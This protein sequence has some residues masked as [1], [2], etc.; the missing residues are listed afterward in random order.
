M[1]KILWIILSFVCLNQSHAD[2]K[3]IIQVE[4]S[5]FFTC[6]LKAQKVSCYGDNEYG[7]LQTPGDIKN[8]K[9]MSVG[10]GSA[11]VLDD[12]GVRCWGSLLGIPMP[13]NLKNVESI[14]SGEMHTC[15][16]LSDNTVKCWGLNTVGQ[17]NVPSGL[18]NVR[19]IAAGGNHTCAVVETT[20]NEDKVICWGVQFPGIGHISQLPPPWLG[21]INLISVSAGHICVVEYAGV[22]E[23][24]MKC[25]GYNLN[26]QAKVPS[27]LKNIRAVSTGEGATC[28]LGVGGP[29]CWGIIYNHELNPLPKLINVRQISMGLEHAC[30]LDDNG[31]KCWGDDYYGESNIPQDP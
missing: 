4:A 22:N 31:V 6:V 21:H 28:V 7:V 9:M 12:N 17:V 18:K 20:A 8:A 26:G 3:S 15:A 10:T 13:S 14:A 25:W 11:C 5:M 23:T 30:A 24:Q 27:G 16:L 2:P 19:A 29:N 1:K